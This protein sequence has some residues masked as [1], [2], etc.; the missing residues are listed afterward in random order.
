MIEYREQ[1]NLFL[2]HGRSTTYAVKIFRNTYL[3]HLYWGPKIDSTGILHHFQPMA[4]PY[5]VDA[6]RE[7]PLFSL[8]SLKREY[9]DYGT[10]DI[11]HPAFTARNSTGDRITDFACK[12][13]RIYGGKPELPGLPSLR[14]HGDDDAETLEIRMRDERTGLECTLYYTVYDQFDVIIRS[15]FFQNTA[16]DPIYLERAYSAS[17]DF[18]DADF[19]A[20]YLH[21]A[22][23]R[24]AWVNRTPLQPG[25]F[26]FG[27]KT[28][29]TGHQQNPFIA[30]ARN[31]TS[32][33]AGEVWGMNLVYSGNFTV[34]TE[35][36]QFSRTRATIGINDCNFSWKL[37][38]G[39]VFYTPEAVLAYSGSGLNGLSQEFHGLYMQRL[40]PEGFAR[41]ERP[42]LINT[43]EAAYFDVSHSRVVS[44]AQEA[45]KLGI[46]LVVLDDGWFKGRNDD[47][48]S[49]GDW[50]TDRD[51]FPDGL[52]AVSGEVQD[53]GLDFGIWIEPEMISENSDLYREHPDWCI[54]VPG[55][56]PSTG[57][58]QL[59]LDFSRQEIRDYIIKVISDVLKEAHVKYVKWD[60]NRQMT[61]LYA[62]AFSPDRQGEAA[63]R[64]ILG[65][66]EVMDSLTSSF[67]E[68]L[69]EGCAGG[70]GRF[71]PG[72]LA[73]MPQIWTSDDT[74]AVERV[75]IQYGTSMAYPV[76]AMGS[77][78]SAVPNHQVGRVTPLTTRGRV[79]MSG[80]FGYELD[81]K[82]LSED[83]KQEIGEQIAFYKEHRKT[84]QF[85][86][87]YRLKSPFPDR[88]SGA[89][90]HIS[91]DRKTVIVSYFQNFA[92]P[93]AGFSKLKLKGIDEDAVYTDPEG[94]LFHGSVLVNAGLPIGYL[95]GDYQSYTVVLQKKDE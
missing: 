8:N 17:V 51:K 78:V 6:G 25:V 94:K 71:D 27:S 36:D 31:T 28:G 7:E 15:S 42:V 33:S 84:F 56:T 95:H 30:L 48:S 37:E 76:A 5:S 43:W 22:W 38:H 92:V 80:V 32:E 61:D 74:D 20:L 52:G 53:I 50:K 16:E 59:V 69:F 44:I 40:V 10:S 70:G 63:H 89:W 2:L 79:A 57:R 67:P 18:D 55:R 66:Y 1:E 58:N 9:P 64:Y 29:A 93:M 23:A 39:Q 82:S 46:E 68:V 83:E 3:A 88:H 26:S 81:P 60:M 77:H 49:L 34:N 45:A 21:G 11:R 4:I 14:S 86:R 75:C 87:F 90:M 91:Q 35:V 41:K 54:K 24:E 12:D 62:S 85:G 47:T 72:I 65:V 73:Y 19:D 13:Y